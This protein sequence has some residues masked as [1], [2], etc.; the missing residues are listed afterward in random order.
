MQLFKG[1]AVE[2]QFDDSFEPVLSGIGLGL[3]EFFEDCYTAYPLG[4]VIFDDARSPL[5]NAIARDIFRVAFAEIFE[6]FVQVGT[7]E[8]YLTVFK[9]IFGDTV[10]VTFTVPD[11]GKLQIDILAQ[12]VELSEFV[13]RYIVDNQYVIDNIIDYEDDFI[14]FQSIKGF[15]SE[16]EL[17][18]MLFEMV[19]AG[20]YTEITLALVP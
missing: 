12:E 4:E 20:V 5:S 16:Y 19:P 10:D 18:Q 2:Q 13:A 3:D 8:A 9:K 15:T 6:A 1:D 17:N 7:F 14:V 11:P